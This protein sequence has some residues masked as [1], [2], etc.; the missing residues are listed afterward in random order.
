MI[1]NFEDVI[2]NFRN[3][4]FYNEIKAE[5]KEEEEEENKFDKTRK[6]TLGN[7][8]IFK[9]FYLLIR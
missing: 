3:M 5:Y 1:S 6:K 9:N 4:I 2:K 7:K 8:V